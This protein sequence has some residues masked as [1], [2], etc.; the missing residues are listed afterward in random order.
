M[1]SDVLGFT[2]VAALVTLSPGADFPL[3]T[4]RALVSSTRAAIVTSAG[5]CSGVLV[6]AALS[7][8]GVAAL[9]AASA[10]AHSVLKVA[11]PGYLVVLGLR[12]LW[13]ARGLVRST[14]TSAGGG[15]RAEPGSSRPAAFGRG[16]LTNLLNPKV[17]VFYVA[18]L[19]Q[20]VSPEDPVL[21]VSLL[22]TS[23]RAGRGHGLV[24]RLGV[25]R[26]PRR[27]R[28]SSTARTGGGRGPHR[29]R[30]ARLRDAAGP[31]PAVG[32]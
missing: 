26:R 21:A 19:P 32:D 20:F 6:W 12:S 29:E 24:R 17:A 31:R 15:E 3:V 27:R 7:A 16:L 2:L 14:R 11:G 22:F 18:V 5:I 23:L 9:L 30:A 13:N 10:T 25:A 8:V 4:R 28:S 1:R